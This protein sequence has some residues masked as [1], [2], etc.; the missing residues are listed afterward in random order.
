VDVEGDGQ[1]DF[2]VEPFVLSGDVSDVTPPEVL[3]TAPTLPL[4]HSE[5]FLPKI[6]VE[7]SA[8]GV[9]S[10][11]VFWDE[12]KLEAESVDLFFEEPGSHL[13]TVKAYDVAGNLRIATSSVEV[14][15]TVDST[16][17]D[18]ERINNLEW[19]KRRAVFVD[20]RQRLRN[21]VRVAKR[22]DVLESRDR[23]GRKILKRIERLEKRF[24]TILMTRFKNALTKYKD[25]GMITEEAFTILQKNIDFVLQAD[26]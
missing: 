2:G 13:L 1:M 18:L 7:D 12:R 17:A 19:I 22:I 5:V 25:R 26:N 14:I 21:A 6:S 8:S 16:I 24:D 11:N 4:L 9:A 23:Q 10:I 20:L 15:A 3:I